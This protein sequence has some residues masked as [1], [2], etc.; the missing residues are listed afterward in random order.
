MAKLADVLT[1]HNLLRSAPAEPYGPRRGRPPKAPEY[2]AATMADL[3]QKLHDDNPRSSVS[4]ATRLWRA[5]GLPE[6]KFVHRLHEARS[7]TQQQGSVKGKP[8]KDDRQLV[9]RMPYFFAVVEDLVGLK[10]GRQA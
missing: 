8:A 4:Q 3:S 1:R 7:I 6:D 2:L 5:S 9:N 10:A